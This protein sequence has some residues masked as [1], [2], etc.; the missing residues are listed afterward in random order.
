MRTASPNASMPAARICRTSTTSD[1]R[2]VRS[3]L[4]RTACARFV[5]DDTRDLLPGATWCI[6]TRE[7]HEV[8]VGADGAVIVE[9]FAPPR[10]DWQGL[11]ETTP[12]E[13]R[14]PR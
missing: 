11:E 7:P 1:A 12:A 3:D 9:A 10:D 6:P 13:P 2:A 8:R 14:W 5:G 4:L